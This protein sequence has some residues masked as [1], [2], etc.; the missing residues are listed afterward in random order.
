MMNWIKNKLKWGLLAAAAGG[1]FL[2]YI[3]WSEGEHIRDVRAR[4]IEAVALIE[5]GKESTRKGNKSYTVDLAWKDASGVDR[6]A[7]EVSISDGFAGKIIEGD[8]LTAGETRIMYLADSVSAAPIVLDDA[9]TQEEENT[10]MF[11]AG[12]VIGGIGI[13]G[14]ALFFLLGRRRQD[15]DA[16]A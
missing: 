1:A 15:A 2:A 12:L 6:K 14:S 5:G 13:V 8:T 4:G 7:S 11:Y 3:G 10:A 9:G 16:T